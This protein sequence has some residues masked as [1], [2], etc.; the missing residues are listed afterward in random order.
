MC[1]GG[2]NILSMML[3]TQCQSKECQENVHSTHNEWM[4]TPLYIYFYDAMNEG[5]NPEKGGNDKY[6]KLIIECDICSVG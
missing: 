2:K 5:K 4:I 1:E 3:S 6:Y